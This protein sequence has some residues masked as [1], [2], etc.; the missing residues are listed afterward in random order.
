M[1]EQ[2]AKS[3]IN[4]GKTN[5]IPPEAA[6]FRGNRVCCFAVRPSIA[7][8][9]IMRDG[10]VGTRALFSMVF[11]AEYEMHDPLDKIYHYFT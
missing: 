1:L 10:T 4:E 5:S 8:A 3:G 9:I 7:I 2:N 11:S 6:G